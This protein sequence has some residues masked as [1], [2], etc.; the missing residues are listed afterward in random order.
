MGFNNA[1]D[2][3]INHN[4]AVL[5][6]FEHYP[7]K[8]IIAKVAIWEQKHKQQENINTDIEREN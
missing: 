5:D 4:L 2:D 1:V 8:T 3:S 6:I 7:I